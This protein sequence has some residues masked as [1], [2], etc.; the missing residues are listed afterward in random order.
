MCC[1]MCDLTDDAHRR[2]EALAQRYSEEGL[3][4]LA[5]A[6]ID[7]PRHSAEEVRQ[8]DEVDYAKVKSG[9]TFVGS[10]GAS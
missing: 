10:A 7:E 2:I 6:Y 1:S 9:M 4:V 5:F 8:L 3:R